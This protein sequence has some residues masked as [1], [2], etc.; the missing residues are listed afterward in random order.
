M[1]DGEFLGRL[2]GFF[3]RKAPAPIVATEPMS[4]PGAYYLSKLIT[5]GVYYP[6]FRDVDGTAYIVVPD[7]Q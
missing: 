6:I 2:Q 7:R 5:P 3:T 1:S 4:K